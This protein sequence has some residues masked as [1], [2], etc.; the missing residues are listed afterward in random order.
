MTKTNG[1]IFPVSWGSGKGI[2]CLAFWLPG[3]GCFYLAKDQRLPGL[4]GGAD[5]DGIV[6]LPLAGLVDNLHGVRPSAGDVGG[7]VG[8]SNTEIRREHCTKFNFK[9]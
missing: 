5:A 6:A 4:N 2:G 7:G 9:K 8:P 3:I 1:K